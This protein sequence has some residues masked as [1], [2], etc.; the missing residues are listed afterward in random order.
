M[1]RCSHCKEYKETDMFPKNK[2]HKD[3]FHHECKDCAN[4]RRKNYIRYKSKRNPDYGKNLSLKRRRE[5]TNWLITNN[6]SCSFCGENEPCCL[7][8]HHIDPSLK[9]MSI[10]AAFRSVSKERVLSEIN[11]CVI[12]CANCHRKLHR[13]KI[14]LLDLTITDH[15]TKQDLATAYQ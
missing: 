8:F 11:K 7:D 13:G 9:K 14:S 5:L 12:L 6:K 1:K 2:S 4:K 10:S 3:G 15:A